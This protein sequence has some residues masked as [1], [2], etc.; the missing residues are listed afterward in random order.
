MGALEAELVERDV[1]N[2]VT[3]T[4]VIEHHSLLVEP[5][6][7]LRVGR[8]AVVEEEGSVVADQVVDDPLLVKRV[9]LQES[10]ELKERTRYSGCTYFST[11]G[12]R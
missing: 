4:F 1:V 5:G 10:E 12:T 3:H 2:R 9:R 11:M 8:R 6:E 7:P